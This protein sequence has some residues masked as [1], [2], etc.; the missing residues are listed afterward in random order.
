MAQL[1]RVRTKWTG[2][3]SPNSLST[4]YFG[5]DVSVTTLAD[6]QACVDRVRD[7]WVA[8]VGNIQI[9]FT[10][11]TEA[12]VDVINITDG[13][14]TGSFNTATRTGQGT[15]AG[16]GLP[17]QNQGLLRWNT[18]TIAD[19]H[20]LRGHTYIPAPMEGSNTLGAP[21]ALYVTRGNAGATAVLAAGTHQLMV[22]HRPILDAG[23][24]VLRAGSAG[25]VTGGVCQPVWSVLR[26]RRQ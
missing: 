1:A 19:G 5:P 9:G 8:M 18:G 13:A 17:A 10:W 26:S 4:H 3:P 11:T 14:L 15:Q 12:A 2:T 21:D 25:P 7:M 23:G 20:R 24:A 22:W 16:D 6:I